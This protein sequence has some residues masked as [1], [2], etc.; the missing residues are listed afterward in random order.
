[1]AWL[2][3]VA[4]EAF[5]AVFLIGGDFAG[6]WQTGVEAQMGD[7]RE[8]RI[9]NVRPKVEFA[10]DPAFIARVADPCDC[11]LSRD[12]RPRVLASQHVLAIPAS[13][14]P[15]PAE[16]HSGSRSDVR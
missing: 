5:D 14:V 10:D 11:G 13:G 8:G 1:M 15:G 3:W 4:L 6:Q 2:S 7:G 16:R 12:R 9:L